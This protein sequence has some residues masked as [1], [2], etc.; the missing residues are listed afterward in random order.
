MAWEIPS[1]LE[2]QKIS[3][4]PQAEGPGLRLSSLLYPVPKDK[5]LTSLKRGKKREIRATPAQELGIEEDFFQTEPSEQPV[6][7][8]SVV[9]C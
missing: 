8:K 2:V 9:T 6:A 1:F 5:A 7:K 3:R 4:Q